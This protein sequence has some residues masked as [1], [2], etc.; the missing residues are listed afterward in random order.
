M[1]RNVIW[2]PLRTMLFLCFFLSAFFALAQTGA[3]RK[4]YRKT[5]LLVSSG[6]YTVAK[7]A[8]VDLDSSLFISSRLHKLSRIEVITEGIDEEYTLKQCNWIDKNNAG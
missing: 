6:F 2:K 7:N 1:E 3:Y 4:D 5:L 8:T